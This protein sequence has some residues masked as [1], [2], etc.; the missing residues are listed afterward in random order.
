MLLYTVLFCATVTE[1][2]CGIV[3]RVNPILLTYILICSNVEFCYCFLTFQRGGILLHYIDI[4]EYHVAV[5]VSTA[6]EALDAA[7][8]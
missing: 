3:D 4:S 6:I 5:S 8:C 2:L 7:W 1:F